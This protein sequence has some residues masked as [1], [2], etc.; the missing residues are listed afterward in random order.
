VIFKIKTITTALIFAAMTF[1]ATAGTI[2]CP[3]TVELVSIHQ[4]GYVGIMLSSMSNYVIVCRLDDTYTPP[5][6]ASIS[7]ATCKAMYAALL[8]A[9]VSRYNISGMY[10]DGDAISASAT[11]GTFAAGLGT[12]VSLRYLPL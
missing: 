9:R 7:P 5:G 12:Q 8:T 4:P 6:A 3:G 11:C 1:N 2:V 10:F